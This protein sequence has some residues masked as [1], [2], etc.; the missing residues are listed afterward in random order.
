MEASAAPSD[1]ALRTPITQ[2]SP[3]NA[4]AVSR[5]RADAGILSSRW[6]DQL[7]LR[8][9]KLIRDVNVNERNKC[10]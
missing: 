7:P 4:V 3:I 9:M 1:S 5:S 8:P 6:W 2:V 10:L